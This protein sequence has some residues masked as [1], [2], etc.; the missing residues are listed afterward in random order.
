LYQL[1][2][3]DFKQCTLQEIKRN[4]EEAADERWAQASDDA[5]SEYYY[6]NQFK[7]IRLIPG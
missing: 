6:L 3:G 7:W 2:N 4:I 5:D 1:T